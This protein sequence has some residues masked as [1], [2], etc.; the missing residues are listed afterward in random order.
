MPQIT[1]V[2]SVL[3][4][5][6]ASACA[7][8]IIHVAAG[9]D[10]Q[11]AIEDAQPGDTILLD[12]G[13]V[14]TGNFRLRNKLEDA[15]VTIAT[16]RPASAPPATGRITP[17]DSAWLA[18]IVSPNELPAVATDPGAHRYRLADLELYAAA[19]VYSLG[20]VALGSAAAT[21]VGD[22]AF[23]IELD[24]LYI[25]GDPEA[26]GK[27]GVTLNS[28]ATVVKDCWISDF[29]HRTQD[30]QAI[31][32][33][34]GPGPFTI[35][36]NYLEGA[37][38]NVMFGG[39]TPKIVGLVPSDI[40][41]RHNL[42]RKPPEWKSLLKANGT[43]LWSVKNILEFKSGRRALVEGNVLENNWVGFDQHGYAIVLTVRTQGGTDPHA[44]VED[45]VIRGNIVRNSVAGVN[46]LG[47]E[48]V[49]GAPLGIARRIEI[50]DNL[51]HDIDQGVWGGPNGPGQARMFQL[52]QGPEEVIIDHNTLIQAGGRVLQFDPFAGAKP[53]GFRF[54]NNIASH[55]P[56]FGTGVAGQGKGVLD[57][58]TPDGV[59]LNNVLAGAAES[60]YPAGNSY[61]SDVA[62]V[63]L[64]PAHRLPEDSPYK[65]AGS[66][67]RDPGADIG[68]LEDVSIPRLYVTM[69]VRPGEYPPDINPGREGTMLVAILSSPSFDAPAMIDRTSLAFGRTGNERS[70]AFCNP[71]GEDV[72][73]DGLP[74]LMCHFETALADFRAGGTEARLKAKT[75]IDTL[76]EGTQRVNIIQEPNDPPAILRGDGRHACRPST[77]GPA[78]EHRLPAYRR[79][80]LG[81]ARLHGQ[82]GREDVAY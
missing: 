45:I 76:V 50:R 71:G 55:G 5:A 16:A 44:V 1:G 35:V 62:E 18:K 40:L 41:I 24:R 82:S 33:F 42:L 34:N 72:N 36:N 9:G 17:A 80:A 51:F 19:G 77:I 6:A 11:Q 48:M 8:S 10:L 78:P 70:L 32:G 23:N 38:E 63:A 58:Y 65:G 39:A 15:I 79:P 59:C 54:T 27:I 49:G 30:T 74:D 20:V 60:D 47:R 52:L 29:K 56:I 64:T 22:L 73:G 25:H 12:S 13:A 61:L 46:V 26:G 21:E 7:Q 2:A 53:V 37:A 31:G 67:G 28:V 4:L 66:D 81:L 14:Y 68:T 57:H 69:G 43:S 75:G 3:C